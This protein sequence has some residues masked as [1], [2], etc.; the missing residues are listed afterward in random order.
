[1]LS[2]REATPEAFEASARD[3]GL[4]HFTG[5]ALVSPVRAEETFLVLSDGRDGEARMSMSRVAALQLAR[6]PLVVLAA[7]STAAGRVTPLE[8]TMSIARA[9][10]AAGAPS[11]VATLWP[12]A[13]DDAATFFT[14]V[15]ELLARG[16]RPADA[17]RET[18]IESIQRS[19]S[20]AMW[21]AVEA[22]GS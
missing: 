18:Q 6:A 3:A 1:L 13:D 11:V 20:P 2:G 17:L 16:E 4:I 14:R 12:I 22:I 9:F 15:H 21:A 5:H 8:G 10:L 7:C 19:I